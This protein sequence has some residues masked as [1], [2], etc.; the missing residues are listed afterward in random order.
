MSPQA[1]QNASSANGDLQPAA[2]AAAGAD[3]GP[4]Q[5]PAWSG[6]AKDCAFAA[7]LLL[8]VL[9]TYQPAWN[10]G[11]VWNDGEVLPGPELRSWHGLYRI[12]F[13]V[14]ATEQY[15]P[16]SFSAFWVEHKLWGDTTVGY[17]LVN[18]FL[19]AVAALLVMLILR[20]LAVPGAYLAAAIFALHPVQV[21]SVAWITELKN[22]LSGVFYLG[23]MLLYLRFD[24]TRKARWYLAALGLF[25][26]AL[27]SK[28]ATVMLPAVLPVIFWWQRGRLSWKRDLLPLAPLFLAAAMAAGVTVWVERREGA[29]GSEFALG[30]VERCLLAGRAIWFYLGKLFWP[31]DLTLIYPRWNVS[32]TVWRQYLFPAAA[33][34]L[35]A[36]SWSLRRRWR[37]PLAAL[38]FFAATLFPV[39]GFFNVY[40]FRYSFVADHFQYLASLGIIT[41]FSAGVAL[42][43]N[44]REGWRKIT[45]QIGCLAL[46]TLLVALSWR[47]TRMFADSETLYRTTVERNPDCWLVHN[48]LGLTRA[49]RGQVD[50]AIA[51]FRK[52]LEIKPNDVESHTNLANALVRRGQVDEGIEHYRKALEIKPDYAEAHSNLGAALAGRGYVDEAIEHYRKAL[53]IKPDNA[54]AHSNLGAALA[55]RGQVDEAIEHYRKALEIKPDFVEVHYNLGNALAGRGQVDEAI[56]HYRKALEIKPDYAEAHD[57]LGI[58]LAGRGHFDE[59]VAQYRKAL[60]IKPGYSEAHNNLAAAL[61]GRGQFDEAIAHFRKALDIDPDYLSARCNLGLALAGCGRVAEAIAQYQKA[62]ALASARNNTALADALRLKLRVGGKPRPGAARLKIRFISSTT[63]TSIRP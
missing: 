11:F 40:F 12:W 54:E 6:G 61:A 52:A 36:V 48:N 3:G 62:L 26:L 1:E 44:R 58:A 34:L 23:T 20:R 41:L 59:A 25:V 38:L 28:T 18:I 17:H 10:G 14:L 42:L 46:L 24:Q 8:A 2:K 45:V 27:L 33:L 21:E 31:V 9:L 43:L 50:E 15:Y 35:L 63:K 32:R 47:Q 51:H 4:P 55:G 56:A 16:M 19:H 39:L 57:N 29:V 37:G 22:T 53:E 7:A 49:S 60:E 30:P 13:D 5:R